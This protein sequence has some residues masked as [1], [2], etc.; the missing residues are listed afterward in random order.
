MA[1]ISKC[2]EPWLFINSIF[3]CNEF[4][5]LLEDVVLEGEEGNEGKCKKSY[6]SNSYFLLKFLNSYRMILSS[7]VLEY[8][9]MFEFKIHGFKG[10]DASAA[11]SK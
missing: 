2:I 4:V 5:S 8:S 9:W 7:L 1:N 6:L 10:F 11:D 3:S